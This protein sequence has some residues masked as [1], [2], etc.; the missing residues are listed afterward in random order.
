MNW[1]EIVGYTGSVL[2]AVSLM[3]SSIVRLRWINLIGAATFATYGLL[4]NAYPVFVLNGFITLVDVYYLIQMSKSADYFELFQIDTLQSPFLLRFLKFHENDISTFFPKFEL[5][6]LKNPIVV[7]ILRNMLP[8]GLFICEKGKNNELEIKIDYVILDYRDSKNAHYLF[9]K[10][11]S[12]FQDQNHKCFIIQTE[13]QSHINYLMKIG[14]KSYEKKGPGWYRRV[15][16][17]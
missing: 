10:E 7:F 17:S 2:V 5:N 15:I 1:I 16:H 3:M 6:E 11:H 8:V 4:V 14:F 12:V 9:Y 13:V